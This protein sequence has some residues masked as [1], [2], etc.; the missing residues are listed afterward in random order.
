MKRGRAGTMT[1]DYKRHGTTTL[2]AALD[3]LTGAVIGQYLPRHANDE[4]LHFLKKV[5][6]EVPAALAVHVILDNY[7]THNHANIRAWLA[8]L[9][10]FHLHFTPTS[11]SWLV[12]V[13]RWFREL[14]EKAI[15]RAVFHS[16]P[17]L[18]TAIQE[19][20]NAHNNDPKPFIWTASAENILTKV[21]R[22]RVVLK[23][24][25]S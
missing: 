21:R 6:R 7:A 15:R 9:P 18:V 14:T 24:V 20:L 4:F 22:G 17:E 2:F 3:V 19:Y 16:V 10:R 11:S 5:D 13:G 8:K 25:A 23:Q 12:L 1:H